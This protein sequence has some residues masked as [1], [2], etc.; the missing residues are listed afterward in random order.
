VARFLTH[1]PLQFPGAKRPKTAAAQAE[2]A[3]VLGKLVPDTSDPDE[4]LPMNLFNHRLHLLDFMQY[5]HFQFDQL[6]RA[7]HSSVG[8][9][10]LLHATLAER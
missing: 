1:A 3:E 6:R 9:V 4:P 8:L 5:N 10:S 7:K 2:D